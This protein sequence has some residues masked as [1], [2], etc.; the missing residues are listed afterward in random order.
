M[1]LI[2]NKK[3]FPELNDFRGILNGFILAIISWIVIILIYFLVK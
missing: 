2:S 3:V 1:M